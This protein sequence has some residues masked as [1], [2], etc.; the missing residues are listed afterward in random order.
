M[1]TATAEEP[2]TESTPLIAARDSAHKPSTELVV[3]PPSP[4]TTAYP[5]SPP[6]PTD[7]PPKP[8]D[9][10]D[11]LD[12]PLP[13]TQIFLL[14]LAR[15]VEPIAFFSIF[16]FVNEMIHDLGG[17]PTESVGYWS[18]WIESVFSLMQTVSMLF[19]GRAA[20]RWGRKPVLVVSLAGV[21]VG[22][23]AFGLAGNVWQMIALRSIAG[24]F[25]GT[26]VT[27]RTMISENST[28]RNQA[29]AFS[30]FMFAGN[31][32]IFIGPIIGGALSKPA[33]Q[34][35][36]VFGGVWVLEKYPYLA[37][38]I[39]SGACTALSCLANALW[40]KETGVSHKDKSATAAKPPSARELLTT[41]GV[42]PALLIFEYVMLI[43]VTFTALLP[44][45]AYTPIA[46]GGWSF[47]APQISL[48]LAAGG[49]G[50]A[51]WILLVFPPLQHRIGTGNVLRITA[52]ARPIGLVA[53]PALNELLRAG[54][55]TAFWVLLPITAIWSSS[56]S[57]SFTAVQL[58]INDI[59]PSP[60]A[61]GT[62]NGIALS[63]SCAIRA[64]GPAAIT[65]LY[66]V[67]V[68]YQLLRGHL[69]WVL[70]IAV[71]LGYLVLLRWL[72]KKCEG[73]VERKRGD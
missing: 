65:S 10:P 57:M 43:S 46:L 30:F 38:C 14:C 51:F 68:R 16:P 22:S 40:L 50:Q 48:Y 55:G 54:K 23:V 1:A 26:L 7:G 25:S 32:G 35:P 13:R 31:L 28:A 67:G 59:S 11:P 27:V 73:R 49:A 61:L 33:T 37:P 66:A 4:S 45:F 53:L 12:R 60:L 70:V 69:A 47:S 2:I 62:L 18:G 3:E 29:R 34:Y 6:S 58:V 52:L 20:D 72:P 36:S 56:V 17:I 9:D 39:V 71:A 42:I 64:V 21:A 63:L 41:P 24:I 19:W 44:L 8:A 15:F 5:T